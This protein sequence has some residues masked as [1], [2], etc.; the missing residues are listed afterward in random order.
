MYIKLNKFIFNIL[1]IVCIASIYII[2]VSMGNQEVDSSLLLFNQLRT[3]IIGL[4]ILLICTTR[5]SKVYTY[6]SISCILLIIALKYFAYKEFDLGY[7]YIL[8]G[9]VS[10]DFILFNG[11]NQKFYKKFINIAFYMYLVQVAYFSI[12]S[13]LSQGQL[14]I[15][16]SFND[17]NYTAYFAFCLGAYFY[18][19][20]SK[21]KAFILFTIGLFTYSRLF[22]VNLALF[23]ILNIY[24]KFF[25]LERLKNKIYNL[26]FYVFIQILILI[27]CTIYIIIYQKVDPSY[28]YVQGFSRLTNMLDESNYMRSMANVL[29]FQS[30]GIGS[31]FLGLKQNTFIGL[32]MFKN[33][34]IFPH[35]L[36]WALYIQY[37]MITS[38][39]FIKRYMKIFKNTNA[40]ITSY[41]VCL[42]IYHSFLGLSSFYGV[43]I[44]IQAIL[45]SIISKAKE[46]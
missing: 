39:L 14:K 16:A 5:K 19:I 10:V 3:I 12:M 2:P 25:K 46:E 27:V 38:M 30:L 36:M 22:I 37:G 4:A 7:L 41:F 34:S 23:T 33:K 15:L 42:I 45:I 35:N 1:A 32:T 9:I 18:F 20:K 17:A 43:D 13:I 44:V 21:K 28:E 6:A 11:I 8:V 31:I 24:Q 40:N 26:R 29:A